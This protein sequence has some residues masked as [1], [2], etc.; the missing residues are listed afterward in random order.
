MQ[1]NI[2]NLTIAGLLALPGFAQ[3]AGVVQLPATNQSVC[4]AAN[5]AVRPCTGTGE[6]GEY[7]SGVS[8][9]LQRFTDNGNGT[10]TD[11]LT[12]LVWSKHANAPLRALAGS[13]PNNCLNAETDMTWLQALDFVTCLN[14]NNHAGANDW[15]LP[16]LNEMESM[17]NSGVA[18]SAAY[19]NAN[20]FGL[21]TSI[22]Q[23]K[24]SQYWTSTSDVSDPVDQFQNSLSAFQAWDM[25][26]GKGDFPF[27]VGKND[28][29]LT[30]GVWPV[31]GTSAA[32]A[33]LW[34]T[35]QTVCFDEVGD[36]RPCA[37]TGEDGE[38]LAGAPFPAQ[39]FLTNAGATVALDRLTGLVWSTETQTPGPLACADTGFN[40]NWQQALNHLS[41]LNS[42]SYLGR[43]DW[44]L[45]NRKELRSLADYSKG[46]PVMPAGHP[47][48]DQSGFSYWS[49]T[50][51]VSLPTEAWSA[52]MFDGSISSSVKTGLLSVW[53]VSGPDLVPPA[54]TINQTSMTIKTANQ[55][56]SGTV[57]I[58][59][60]VNVSVNGGTPV[61][62][63]VNGTN[64]SYTLTSLP[65]GLNA[66][67]VT[68]ADFSENQSSASVNLTFV[69]PDGIMTGGGVVRVE[70]ALR[71]LRIAVGL[72]AP[73]ADD[74][75][76]G[77]VAP[78]GNPDNTIGVADAIMILRKVA[79]LPSF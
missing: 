24:S 59:A 52:S 20:G 69:A 76:H 4:Y 39:R 5:G 31:R 13:Q 43:N 77:D 6:D 64:W 41:C 35:G 7:R 32:P 73:T 23:V 70:D 66:V 57:E 8:W 25:D 72:V 22:S 2:L 78:V 62:A 40:L 68:A 1:K 74:L 42:N 3:A 71:A 51:N 33:R 63:A 79:G 47:F 60:S 38:K 55:N 16:N 12:R 61:V 44:R 18:D 45:P 28:P 54:I 14:T 48:S 49:S 75:L 19:L 34:R 50:T 27:S 15:R 37:G 10:V 9:P 67:T 29:L 36:V 30:R 53:P 11:Q 46:G 56:L 21:G 17:I 65:V 58:G 26:L